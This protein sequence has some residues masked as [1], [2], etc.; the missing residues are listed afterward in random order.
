MKQ[1]EPDPSYSAVVRQVLDRV[2][3]DLYLYPYNVIATRPQCGIIEVVPQSKVSSL[4]LF[5][6]FLMLFFT[7]S[8]F[9]I[10]KIF[11]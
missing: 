3:L 10:F 4:L 8:N 11:Q 7:T 5:S 9:Y 1:C 6:F 2:G